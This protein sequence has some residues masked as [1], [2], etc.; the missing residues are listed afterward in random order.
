[1]RLSCTRLLLVTITMTAA[2]PLQSPGEAPSLFDSP[3]NVKLPFAD[4]LTPGAGFAGGGLPKPGSAPA[5][6]K[7]LLYIKKSKL[8]LYETARYAKRTSVHYASLFVQWQ[9]KVPPKKS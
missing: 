1:M 6:P 8:P 2:M 3:I 7:P 4:F 9:V 5:D